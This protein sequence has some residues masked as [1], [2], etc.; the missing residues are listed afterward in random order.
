M[1]HTLT[2]ELPNDAYVQ[3]ETAARQIGKT[4]DMLVVELLTSQL[5]P[6]AAPS[7]R[8]Q[9]TVAL[10][11]AG[12]LAEPSAEMQH[13]ATQGATI[14]EAAVRQALSRAGGT[15]LSEMVLEQRGPKA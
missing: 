10:Q 5:L 7:E 9:V 14:S 6:V 8:D 1:M 13:I 12:M 3:L 11:A 2:I 4:V 15:P